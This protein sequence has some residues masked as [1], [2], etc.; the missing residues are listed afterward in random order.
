LAK[1]IVLV[2]VLM[3]GVS[4]HVSFLFPV[5]PQGSDA[6]SGVQEQLQD[7]GVSIVKLR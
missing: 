7:G 6:V 4:P 5:H 3:P 2:A 1:V